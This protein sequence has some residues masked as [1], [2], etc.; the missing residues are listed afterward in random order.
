MSAA[1]RGDEDFEQKATWLTTTLLWHLTPRS[2]TAVRLS[3]ALSGP[4]SGA[5]CASTGAAT[6]PARTRE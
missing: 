3:G 5:R 4:C 2:P 1:F 6:S